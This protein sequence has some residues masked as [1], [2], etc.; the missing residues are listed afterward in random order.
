MD[1]A[2][3][4]RHVLVLS[5]ACGT[6]DGGMGGTFQDHNVRFQR[7]GKWYLQRASRREGMDAIGA[8]KCRGWT[9]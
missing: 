1:V 8:C 3:F 2:P 7:R 9:G 5:M 4:S 6:G